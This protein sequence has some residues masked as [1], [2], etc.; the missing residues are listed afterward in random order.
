VFEFRDA[1]LFSDPSDLGGFLILAKVDLDREI[2]A[3]SP[4]DVKLE[5]VASVIGE[6]QAKSFVAT[7]RPIPTA[8]W[9]TGLPGIR[10]NAGER[11]VGNAYDI[12][13]EIVERIANM[14]SEGT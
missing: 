9:V 8:V 2:P 5:P 7:D 13:R 4:P 12:K 1:N 3:G 6:R 10:A 14:P 11:L